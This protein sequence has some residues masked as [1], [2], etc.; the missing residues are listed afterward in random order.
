MPQPVRV[1]IATAAEVPGVDPDDRR[2]AAALQDR[3]AEASVAV[4]DDPTVAWERFDAVVLRSTWDYAPRRGEF[5][6]WAEGVAARS[7]LVN[8]LDLV[9]WNT[10]KRY[11]HAL[12]AAG[13]PVVPTTWVEPGDRWEVPTADEYVVKPVVSAGSKDT[14]RYR[15]GADDDRARAHVAA[16]T[17]AGRAVMVQPYVGTVD[18]HGETAVVIVGGRVSHA[19]RKGPIL[20][21]GVG[22]VEGLYAEE[23]IRPRTPAA[24][25]LA[26]A[27][28]VVAATPGGRDRVAYGRVDLVRGERG[29][30]L[31]LEYELTEPSLFLEHGPD[32]A[33]QLADVVLDLV[34]PRA[35]PRTGR[36]R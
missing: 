33:G 2:F 29:Q 21:P 18:E 6:A 7:V 31:V 13:V 19:I 22:L 3:G 32:A 36:L 25:E 10:D 24:D 30:P 12:G 9:V 17:A 8:P 4:W 1:A 14:A 15:R 23:D 28:Q 20:R 11:L 35:R 26:L 5:L 27:E 34:R 16:L